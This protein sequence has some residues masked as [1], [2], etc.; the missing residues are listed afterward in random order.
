MLTT[1]WESLL[2]NLTYLALVIGIWLV[3]LA[4]VTP[5][6]GLYEMTAAIWLALAALGMLL[7]PL[8][9]WSLIP[10]LVGLASFV[11]AIASRRGTLWLLIL[12][13][14]FFSAGSVWLFS[15]G[16]DAVG[17]HPVVATLISLLSVGFYGLAMRKVL[18]AQR[19]RPM[20]DPSAVVGHAGE[21]RTEINPVGTV[22]VQGELWSARAA[23]PIPRGRRVKVIAKEGLVLQVEPIS[24]QD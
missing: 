19:K 17:V 12:A 22:Y 21:A 18:E 6:T 11:A 24:D 3:S 5:G 7:V 23:E 1:S 14:L 20:V 4:M 2:P 16:E 15:A 10:L 9:P 8:N 13:A